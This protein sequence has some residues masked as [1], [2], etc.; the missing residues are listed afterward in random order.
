MEWN[1]FPFIAD[2]SLSYFLTNITSVTPVSLVMIA[3][4]HVFRLLARKGRGIPQAVGRQ[5]L[6]RAREEPRRGT[7]PPN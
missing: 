1:F 4:G 7:P 2:K 5:V 3:A 6:N